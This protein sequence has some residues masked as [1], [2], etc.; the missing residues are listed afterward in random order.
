[1]ISHQTV[2]LLGALVMALSDAETTAIRRAAGLSPSGCAALVSVGQNAGINI[3]GLSSILGLTHSVTVRLVERLVED[4][5]INRVAGTDRRHVVLELSDFGKARSAAILKTRAE[6]ARR[7][8]ATLELEQQRQIEPILSTMLTALTTSRTQADHLCRLC[9]ETVCQ[10]D[11]CPVE[12]QA[13]RIEAAL[14]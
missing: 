14:P 1:M 11:S 7:L 3:G 5:L 12:R 13:R 4:K 6:V 10:S 2:N 9:D 8:L